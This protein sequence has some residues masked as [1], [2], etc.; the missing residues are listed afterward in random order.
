MQNPNKKIT[1]LFYSPKFITLVGFIVLIL[2]S[3]PLA[4]NISRRYLVDQEIM[5][6]EQEITDLESKNKD[7]KDFVSYLESDQFVEEQARLKLGLKK[8]GEEVV[9]LKANLNASSSLLNLTD[10]NNLN[11]SHPQKWW[12]YF[13][14]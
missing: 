5:D 8:P 14:N 7:F 2:V 4:K 1:K 9:V 6:L 3:I 13:F 10:D 12:N 11:I